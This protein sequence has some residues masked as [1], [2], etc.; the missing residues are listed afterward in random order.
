MMSGT[1]CSTP[2]VAALVALLYQ[3]HDTYQVRLKLGSENRFKTPKAVRAILRQMSR[4][5]S[6]ENYNLLVP[7]VGR[8]DRFQFPSTQDEEQRTFGTTLHQRPQAG[9]GFFKERL[10]DILDKAKV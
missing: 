2:I 8:E 4:T 10:G 6:G 3:F 7:W 5:S 1:S 9:V